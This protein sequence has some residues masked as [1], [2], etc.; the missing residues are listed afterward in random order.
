MLEEFLPGPIAGPRARGSLAGPHLDGFSEWLRDLG[1]SAESIQQFLWAAIHL[2]IWLART[3]TSLTA[4]DE[5]QIERFRQHLRRCSCPGLRRLRTRTARI[6]RRAGRFLEYLREQHVAP[7]AAGIPAPAVHP[8]LVDFEAWMCQHRGVSPST[9]RIYRRILADALQALGEDPTT[10]DP[11][12]VRAF[13]LRRSRAQGRSIA[14]LVMTAMRG[15]LRFLIARGACRHGLDRAVPTV[16]G[17]RLASLPRFLSSEDIDRVIG[18][19]DPETLAGRRNR[20]ILLLLARLGLRASDVAALRL[21]QLDWSTGTIDVSGKSRRE[22]RLPLP[23]EVGDAILAYLPFRPQAPTDR[24]FVRLCPPCGPLMPS[25]VSSVAAR[26]IRVSGIAAPAR[27]AHVFRHSA[28]SALIRDG[29]SL[30]QVQLVL[31]HRDPETTRIYAKVD[32][33]MLRAIAQPWPEVAP[34]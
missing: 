13:V 2:A 14:K 3:R 11:R 33:G 9:L 10:Y 34:C 19:C 12:G 6:A 25:A 17:W 5:T 27:G 23:Q 16:A 26:A 24:L 20:A 4:L 28:A 21:Q 15:F 1:Y 31:R 22:T 8:L 32:I 7:K 29:A 30:D 18:T